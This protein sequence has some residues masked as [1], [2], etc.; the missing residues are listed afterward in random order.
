M[1]HLPLPPTGDQLF[2]PS[3]PTEGTVPGEE[4]SMV[5]LDK[6]VVKVHLGSFRNFI[7][8]LHTFSEASAPPPRLGPGRATTATDPVL[9]RA[10]LEV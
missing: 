10:Q 1:A 3:R 2:G 7:A 6:K 8:F 9:V 4:R 5:S